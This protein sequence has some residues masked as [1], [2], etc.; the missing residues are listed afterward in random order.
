MNELRCAGLPASWVNGWL[1][2]VGATV[3]S[4]NLR[5]RWTEHG[6]PKAVLCAEKEDPAAVLAR[7][8]PSRAIVESMPI[9]RRWP[10]SKDLPRNVPVDAFQAR[11]AAVRADP[12]SWTLSSTLTDLHVDEKGNVA[13]APFDPP[14]PRGYIIHDRLMRLHSDPSTEDLHRTLEGTG[15]RID[16]NGLGFDITRIGSEADGSSKWIDPV[17]ET[18]AF[19]GLALFPVRGLG[20]DARI[21]RRVRTSTIQRGWVWD[22]ERP[23]QPRFIWPAWRLPLDRAAI[24]ALL[25]L[26]RADRKGT[27]SGFGIH[28]AWRSVSYKPKGTSDVT[29][30]FGA[31]RLD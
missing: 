20:T 27:W 29:R 2:A 7:S 11:G 30:G 28:A 21:G 9:R 15:K 16:S 18:L 4:P 17:V 31:E 8:W 13:H 23:P 22:G 5:L 1:A 12:L 24:D 3:L 6:T 25:D 10:N 26:W 14:A 19:F